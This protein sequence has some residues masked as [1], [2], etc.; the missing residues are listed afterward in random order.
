MTH[1]KFDYSKA[2]RFFEEREL[3]Y[4]E[5]AVKAAHDSLHNGT[6]AGN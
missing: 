5:P 4:L 1:I 3:D 2:L 6:G